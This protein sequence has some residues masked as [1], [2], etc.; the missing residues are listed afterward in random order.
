[1]DALNL[2]QRITRNTNIDFKLAQPDAAHVI[3]DAIHNMANIKV[4]DEQLALFL[5]YQDGPRIFEHI[6]KESAMHINKLERDLSNLKAKAFSSGWILDI[7]LL[8][9]DIWLYDG[10]QPRTHE[11]IFEFC[12]EDYYT[13]LPF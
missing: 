9:R 4:Y 5:G 3:E 2:E 13:A 8:R 12:Y 11:V 6:A 7:K 10:N 1:M